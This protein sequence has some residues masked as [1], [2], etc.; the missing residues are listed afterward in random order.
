MFSPYCPQLYGAKRDEMPPVSFGVC[1][2]GCMHLFKYLFP[3]SS[4]TFLLLPKIVVIVR[5]RSSKG[6][7][8]NTFIEGS[9]RL[10]FSSSLR[11]SITS[12]GMLYSFILLFTFVVYI[13]GKMWLCGS[14]VVGLVSYHLIFAILC[15]WG[16]LTTPKPSFPL[17]SV[18]LRR[19][20]S[21]VGR[22]M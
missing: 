1:G 22:P 3:F 5:E 12:T 13:L 17:S 14:A 9:L 15:R 6:T 21:S 11:I 7:R 18:A 8:D 16:V 2:K 20:N 4:L 10:I 19:L